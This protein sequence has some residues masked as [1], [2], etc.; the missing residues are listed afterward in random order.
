MKRIIAILLT[1]AT[2]FSIMT[3][4]GCNNKTVK[5]YTRGEWVSALSELFG[6][7]EPYNLEPYFEDVDGNDPV[8]NAVQNCV[9]W[10][11]IEKSDK[12]NPND[13]A[14]VNFAIETA[15]KAIGLE[16]IENSIDGE[17]L[18]TSKAC[19]DYFNEK[20]NVKYISGSNLYM[21]TAES[22]LKD[23]SRI[24]SEMEMKQKYEFNYAD[25]TRVFTEKDI[26]FSMDGTSA[27]LNNKTAKVG[28]IISVEPS[29]YYPKGK[30]AKVTAVDG[31]KINYVTPELDELIKNVDISGTYTPEILGVIPLMEGVKVKSI[32]GS[33]IKSQA[34]YGSEGNGQIIFLKDDEDKSINLGNV[35]IEIENATPGNY[36]SFAIGGSVALKNITITPDFDIKGII[37]NKAAAT[38][39]STLEATIKL[40][41]GTINSGDK[42]EKSWPLAQIPCKLYGAIGVTFVLAL[43]VGL[44]GEITIDFS[45]DTSAGFE[46]KP[47]RSAKFHANG[48]N[49]NVDLS[50]T[51]K[52][53]AKPEVRV[54]FEI[55]PVDVASVGVNGGIEAS[56]TTKLI[57]TSDDVGCID[58]DAYVPL[59]I[60]VGAE[61]K[62]TLLGKLGV[63]KSWKIWTK[64]NSIWKKNWH[65]ENWEIVEECT[66]GKEAEETEGTV[67]EYDSIQSDEPLDNNFFE[68]M[69]ISA[70]Y[71][72][73]EEGKSDK[74]VVTHLPV[75]YNQT[76]I[77][78]ES[79]NS[80]IV[81]VD[82]NGNV[83]GVSQG[84][85][86]IKVYTSDNKYAQ[87]CAVRVLAS[88]YVEFTPLMNY[89]V[90]LNGISA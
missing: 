54:D 19:I 52:A 72:V 22:V 37:V 87:Y 25:N 69:S 7:E 76:D 16:R 56:A 67:D 79:G 10:E 13:R 62:E 61:N 86:T 80:H 77:R 48:S 4:T 78:F 8:F 81:R 82:A 83:T 28:D 59:S 2:V 38:V 3:T 33:A 44:E 12:F 15:I 21:D 5:I 29:A 24:Y 47:F 68:T 20:S 74:L 34:F 63:K 89:G 11:I 70:F 43:K 88:Y 53:Y 17:K 23:I 42:F 65:V 90:S 41:S 6:M 55:G 71:A 9:E 64:D 60:F 26:V 45:V 49:P 1:I 50:I 66:K 39:N 57:G 85:T 14:D 18:N 27:I 58:L 36:A 31:N 84:V 46:Y 35:E 30:Y 51:A 75:G 73:L 32:D 40:A